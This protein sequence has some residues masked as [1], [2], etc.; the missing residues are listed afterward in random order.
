MGKKHD[1]KML[2]W[3]V[4]AIWPYEIA[5]EE[6]V[7]R[8]ESEWQKRRLAIEQAIETAET[9]VE[10]VKEHVQ[11]YH[12]RKKLHKQLI[13]DIMCDFE[14]QPENRFSMEEIK[15]ILTAYRRRELRLPPTTP[16]E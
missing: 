10:K 5:D 4:C 8:T 13:D 3:A 7:D 9:M 6:K 12:I 15:E 11:Y 1:E 16:E 2:L 14:D